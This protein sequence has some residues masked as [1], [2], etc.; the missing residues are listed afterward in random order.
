MALG[1]DNITTRG[2]PEEVVKEDD[3]GVALSVPEGEHWP[4]VT[5]SVYMERP[6]CT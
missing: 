1:P 4:G 2:L 6:L 3:P 5:V